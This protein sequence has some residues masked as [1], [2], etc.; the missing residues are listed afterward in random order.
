MSTTARFTAPAARARGR[1]RQLTAFSPRLGRQLT[2]GG[3]GA[4]RLWLMIEA[5][6]SIVAFCERPLVIQ[7]AGR[8]RAVDF[9][10]QQ[11]DG[12]EALLCLWHRPE[13]IDPPV[14]DS[15]MVRAVGD[16]E[17]RATQMWTNNW[18][19]I[20]PVLVATR[21]LVKPALR[22]EILKRCARPLA[23]AALQRLDIEPDPM[24]LRGAVFDLLHRGWL[25]AEALRT[26]SVS[27][28]TQFVCTR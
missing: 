12:E 3:G 1:E 10:V 4:H 26:E 13:P 15:M 18:E 2:L 7:I 25:Q 8:E 9:W 19:R 24:L 27:P 6:A 20:L 21:G 16:A 5:D 17:I 23:L 28:L 14:W 22:D 11:A